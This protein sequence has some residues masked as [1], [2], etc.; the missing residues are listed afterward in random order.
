MGS[1]LP[2]LFGDVQ[3]RQ[4][5]SSCTLKV[6]WG[7][8]GASFPALQPY[9]SQKNSI[10]EECWLKGAGRLDAGG[11]SSPLLCS[12]VIYHQDTHFINIK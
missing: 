2:C 4:Q 12:L 8:E 10:T 7:K 3:L 1:P 11:A 6:G 5:L 9:Q